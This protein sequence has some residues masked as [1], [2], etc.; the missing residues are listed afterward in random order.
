MS[1]EIA[2]ARHSILVVDDTPANLQ[3]L[4]VMLKERGYKVRPAPSG[5]M[6]LRAAQ[7]TPPDLVLLDI[8]MP[9]MDGYEV[10]A[11]LKA[12]ARLRDIPVLFISALTDSQDKVR[13]F[14][15]GGVDYVTKPFNFE[16]IDARVRT[17]LELRRQK[18]EL[19]ASLVRL[20]EVERLRDSLTHMI[21]HDM[22]SP[23]LVIGMTFEFL[24]PLIE[25]ADA[26][27]AA[28]ARDAQREAAS[29]I[30]MITQML[31]VSRMEAGALKPK[32][33]PGNVE[34][35]VRRGVEGLRALAG[36]RRLLVSAPGPLEA[37]FDADLVRRVVANLVSNAIKFTTAEGEVRVALKSQSGLIRVEVIDN[38]R[39]IAPEQ[40]RKIF[41]K[42]G[43]V[44][45]KGKPRIGTGLGLTFA[46]MAIEAHGGQI[47]VESA[48]GQGSTFWFSLPAPAPRAV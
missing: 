11:R 37:E 14:Q 38:G 7:I 46:R 6:A 44:E 26:E 47:G 24:L 16:E 12:D 43:Q 22:R 21:A 30:E 34:E 2:A 42:F 10:C 3:L 39:G 20:Q 25:K 28:L 48:V 32:L 19:A 29:N 27:V 40:H 1:P 45:D 4:T 17:H 35:V 33:A 23:L 18:Q 31:D 36:K 15:A 41:E 13:A 8:N 5:A 9:E